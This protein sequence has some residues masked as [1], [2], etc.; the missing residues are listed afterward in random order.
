MV[1]FILEGLDTDLSLTTK[2][3]FPSPVSSA[4]TGHLFT[5][6]ANVTKEDFA[7]IFYFNTTAPELTSSTADDDMKFYTVPTNWPDIAFSDGVITGDGSDAGS[8]NVSSYSPPPS[9]NGVHY[10]KNIGPAFLAKQITGGYNNSDI[11]SNEDA[12][13]QQYVTLD[14][15]G[16]APTSSTNDVSGKGIQQHIQ[17]K[18]FAAGTDVANGVGDVLPLS[19]NDT[20]T[21]NLSRELFLQ[22]KD[23]SF[24]RL[25][26]LIASGGTDVNNNLRNVPITF[27]DGDT[28]EFKL[29]YN[30][31]NI[32][33][34]GENSPAVDGAGNTLGSNNISNQIF[35][36]KLVMN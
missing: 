36:V 8:E 27:E 32:A 10:T 21:A 14:S 33:S 7:T 11:F 13:V 18:L 9:A 4:V 20:T 17:K 5:L 24:N 6:T 15:A 12:L 25:A 3:T 34:A 16:S 30:V 28:I 1:N 22:L 26:T 19:N 29:T 35:R 31:S 2:P 23:S